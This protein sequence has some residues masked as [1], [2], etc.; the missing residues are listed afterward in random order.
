VKVQF[1]N[2]LGSPQKQK[3]DIEVQ[4][5]ATAGTIQNIRIPEGKSYG[6]TTLTSSLQCGTVTVSANSGGKTAATNLQFVCTDAALELAAIPPDIP[7]DGKSTSTI[8]IRTKN[9]NGQVISFLNERT[10]E[11]TTT[12]GTVTSPVKIAAGALEGTAVL[13]SGQISGIATVNAVADKQ[14]RGAGS[15]KLGELAKRYCM[16]CGSPMSMDAQS[17]PKCGKTPPSGVDTKVCPACGAVLPTTAV[18]CDRCG[19][20][21]G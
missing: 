6:E 20:K 4:M 17:C 12:L 11:L 8:I 10:V 9:K 7:A 1:I 21:Q 13:T 15:V 18:Y 5:S 2:G 19:S 14:V 3:N 16:H